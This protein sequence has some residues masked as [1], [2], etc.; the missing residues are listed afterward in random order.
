MSAC[1]TWNIEINIL[2]YENE[3]FSL[4]AAFESNIFMISSNSLFE[5]INVV[6]PDPKFSF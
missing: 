1:D 2:V 3:M 4:P 6:I 5:N